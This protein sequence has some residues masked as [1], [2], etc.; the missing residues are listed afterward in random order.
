MT[1]NDDFSLFNPLTMDNKI[2]P[3]KLGNYLI[4]LR[5]TVSLPQNTSINTIPQFVSIKHY[6]ECYTVIYIEKSIKKIQ[7]SYKLHFQGTADNSTLRKSLGCLMGFELKS[8]DIYSYSSP[9]KKK[10]SDMDEQQLTEW[11][12]KNLLILYY[13]NKDFK[14][15]GQELMKTYNPPLN[16]QGNFYKVNAEYRKQLSALRTN[17]GLVYQTI[18]TETKQHSRSSCPNCGVNLTIPDSLTKEEYIKCLSCGYLFTNPLYL[19]NKKSKE[20]RQ[21]KIALILIGI[22]LIFNLATREKSISD[23]SSNN[24]IENYENKKGPSQT[25]AM[26]GVKTYLKRHYL[27][28]PDSYQGISWGAFGT[29]KDNTYFALHKYR[30]KNSYA[31]YVVEEKLFVLD[32]DGNVINVVDDMNEIIND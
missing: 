20:S 12:K 16:L 31:G 11:M 2:L 21:W 27:K 9:P 1:Q 15:I 10:F 19:Q 5:S 13:A 30:A 29:Y 26:A 18:T 32:S 8:N 23:K 24:R 28:D 6:E 3:N 22:V 25:R 4:V 14:N 7:E 17:T